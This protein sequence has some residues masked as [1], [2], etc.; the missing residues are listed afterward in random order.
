MPA[1]LSIQLMSHRRSSA[2]DLRTEHWPGTLNQAKRDSRWNGIVRM[3]LSGSICL[4]F[5]D[6]ISCCHAWAIQLRECC[7]NA[8]LEMFCKLWCELLTNSAAA[9][10]TI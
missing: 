5:P 10:E 6:Q 4:L 9:P 7:K 2:W 8:L 1:A 3:I